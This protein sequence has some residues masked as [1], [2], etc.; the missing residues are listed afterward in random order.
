MKVKLAPG[1][2]VP[3]ET[4]VFNE[5]RVRVPDGQVAP[6]DGTQV[7]GVFALYKELVL[8]GSVSVTPAAL[9]E[10]LLATTIW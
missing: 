9:V 4:P 10:E 8:E 1:A 2:R 7:T 5:E 3:R 6:D